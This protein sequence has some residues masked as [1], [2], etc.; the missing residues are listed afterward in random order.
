[1]LAVGG[2]HPGV[3]VVMLDDAVGHQVEVL[4][5]LGVG[6]LAADQSLDGKE[7][8]LG[9]GDRLA[10]GR[11]AN[12]DLAILGEGDDRRRGAVALG[13]LDDLGVAAFHDGD[14]AVG[15]AEVDADDLAHCLA[16]WM[17]L[18]SVWRPSAA[19]GSDVGA[20]GGASSPAVHSAATTTMAGRSR[21]SLST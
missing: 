2:L 10:L 14:A 5:D 18:D 12:D 9:I 17:S 19:A 4:L 21:R 16:P 15:R 13:V 11:G 1:L 8:V 3:A 20:S 7:G 6:E